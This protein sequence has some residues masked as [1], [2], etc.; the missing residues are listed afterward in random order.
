MGD[1]VFVAHGNRLVNELRKMDCMTGEMWENEPPFRLV[2]NRAAFD[3]TTLHCK[4]Y[5]GRGIMKFRNDGPTTLVLM[6]CCRLLLR[7]HRYL[8]LA[9]C[10]LVL[11]LVAHSL[12]DMF[13]V[14]LGALVM[15]GN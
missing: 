1:L 4:H 7:S 9:L 3:D 12:C 14:A 15:L 5:T 8:G 6:S 10:S 11:R 13:G 2:L